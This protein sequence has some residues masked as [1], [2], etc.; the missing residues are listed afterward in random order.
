ASP[1]NHPPITE[2]S[3]LHPGRLHR[4]GHCCDPGNYL[5]VGVFEETGREMLRW[6]R[7]QGFK[8]LPVR[9]DDP[10]AGDGP[11]DRVGLSKGG[12]RTR[13]RHEPSSLM[14]PGN[15]A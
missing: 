15:R 8:L 10:T 6:I 4:L 2:G 12:D 9:P 7:A 11:G 14:L 13:R 3:I 5:V 1:R